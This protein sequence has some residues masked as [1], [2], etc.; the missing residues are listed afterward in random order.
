MIE[1]ILRHHKKSLGKD[2]QP[3]LNHALR[4]YE[5]ALILL[6]QRESKKLQVV[7]AFHDLDIWKSNSMNYLK[8]SENMAAD[9]IK[10]NRIDLLSDEVKFIISN[11]HKL[12]RIK[13]NVEAEAFRKADLIDLSSGWI[14]YNIPKSLIVESERKYPRMG[15]TWIVVKKVLKYA[16]LHPWN[17]FPMLRF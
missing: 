15:F 1:K 14:S 10:I 7:S 17:P 2:Y 5:Y 16:L 9:Y 4:V 3:Y 6:L 12:T 11:H 13:G 8:G